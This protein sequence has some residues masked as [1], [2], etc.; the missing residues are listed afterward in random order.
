MASKKFDKHLR[1]RLI[2]ARSLSFKYSR[3]PY[4]SA[5]DRVLVDRHNE[6]VKF[7]KHCAGRREKEKI[8]K[9]GEIG[10][11][12]RERKRERMNLMINIKSVSYSI[13]VGYC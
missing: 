1:N 5:P 9:D 12:A 7:E 10:A 13:N 2:A 6:K 3:C 11:I 4:K 8:Y